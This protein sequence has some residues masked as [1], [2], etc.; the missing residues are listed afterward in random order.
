MKIT[1]ELS[2]R[3]EGTSAPWWSIIDPRQNLRLGVDGIYNVASMITGPFFS[4]QEAE[5]FLQAT[6][7]N[8]SKHAKVFC[9]SGCYSRQYSEAVRNAERTKS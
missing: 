4:R 9:H 2:E 6:H 1:I 8:F 5:N 7:Y 3:N